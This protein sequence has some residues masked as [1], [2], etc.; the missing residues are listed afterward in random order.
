MGRREN[1]KSAEINPVRE[2]VAIR[3]GKSPDIMMMLFGSWKK[4]EKK[5]AFLGNTKKK[6]KGHL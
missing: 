2:I 1:D 3:P 4:K 6:E 5:E